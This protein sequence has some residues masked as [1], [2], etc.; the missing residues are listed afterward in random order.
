MMKQVETIEEKL[1]L[2]PDMQYLIDWC[3]QWMKSDR[4][5]G[6]VQLIKGWKMSGFA[7]SAQV[8]HRVGFDSNRIYV[9][10]IWS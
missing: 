8:T 2:R 6:G 5:A 1:R 10:L 7:L 4:E 9:Y 3:I